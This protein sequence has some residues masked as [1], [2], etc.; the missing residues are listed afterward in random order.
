MRN[1]LVDEFAT[2]L[3]EGGHYVIKTFAVATNTGN[4]LATN[5]KY[6]INFTMATLVKE[7]KH[8]VNPIPLFNLVD[9]DTIL[10]LIKPEQY[11][12]G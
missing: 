11:L 5:H 2:S 12:V 6:K 10:K 4:Y 3:K 8:E 9:N 7:C 1:T